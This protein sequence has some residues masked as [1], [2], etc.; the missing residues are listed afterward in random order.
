MKYILDFLKRNTIES[1]VIINGSGEI[2]SYSENIAQIKKNIKDSNNFKDLLWI[3]EAGKF[4]TF[5]SNLA[6]TGNDEQ[7][8]EIMNLENKY[9][10]SQIAGYEFEGEKAQYILLIGHQ[11]HQYIANLSE[12]SKYKQFTNDFRILFN[13]IYFSVN[14]KLELEQIYGN[15]FGLTGY[16]EKELLENVKKL[17]TLVFSEDM[18]QFKVIQS[19]QDIGTTVQKYKIRIIGKDKNKRWVNIEFRSFKINNQDYIKGI[20][21]EV[22]SNQDDENDLATTNEQLIQLAN[23][24]EQVREQERKEMAREIHDE[25]GHALTSLKLDI[26]L[27]IK[28]KYLREDALLTRLNDMMKQIEETIKTLQRISSQLRPSILDHFGLIAALE[29]QAKEFQRQTSIRC[30]YLFQEEEI[31]LEESK[32]IAVFRIFQEILT[33][34]ARHSQATRVDV[35]LT[36][37]NNILELKVSDNGIGIKKENLQSPYSLGLIGMRERANL[38]KG[39]LYINTVLNV[40]T[41]VTLNVSI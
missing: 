12:L 18:E 13:G 33:N 15:T 8:F 5:L 20:I 32:S 41:T 16:S 19:I 4:N 36:I 23:H 25:I 31:E 39:K 3:E 34:I 14:K 24:L 29:W 1:Y 10:V 2:I 37:E 38:M 6:K 9:E 11:H 17:D 40:G 7:V 30:K 27:L 26:N 21:S 35:F 28:K 22:Q